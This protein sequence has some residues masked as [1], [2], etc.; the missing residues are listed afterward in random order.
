MEKSKVQS[1][2][3]LKVWE[4][5]HSFTLSIYRLTQ[6]FPTE[7]KFGLVAQI[8]RS[9]SSIPAN[10]VEGHARTSR[11]DFSHFLTMAK[12]SLEESKYFLILSRDLGYLSNDSY[13]E[14]SSQAAEI[15]RMLFGFQQKLNKT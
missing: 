6:K 10:I 4:K 14:L 8:R 2:K 9:A 11:K 15:G 1:F 3:D 5:A 13:D 7:E 12:G